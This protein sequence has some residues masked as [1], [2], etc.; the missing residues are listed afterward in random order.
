MKYRNWPENK[1]IP[2]YME[3]IEGYVMPEDVEP[4]FPGHDL[5]FGSWIF[6]LHDGMWW[7]LKNHCYTEN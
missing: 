1:K 2:E 6:Y 3:V 5:L 4:F 7:D